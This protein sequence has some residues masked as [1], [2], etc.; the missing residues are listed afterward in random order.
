[1][2]GIKYIT[3]EKGNKQSIVIDLKKWGEYIDD[4]LDAIEASQRLKE[5]SV[6]YKSA[7]KKFIKK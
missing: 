3:D 7:R 1:M 4:I 5:P 6:S 2:T